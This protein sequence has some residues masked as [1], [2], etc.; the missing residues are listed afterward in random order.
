LTGRFA[1]VRLFAAMNLRTEP[2]RLCFAVAW[3]LPSCLALV[4]MA[5]CNQD[6]P[7]DG[8]SIDPSATDA[9]GRP[10]RRSPTVPT[11]SPSLLQNRE[12]ETSAQILAF[13]TGDRQSS[14]ILLEKRF[15]TQARLG[16]VYRYE[17]KVT[18]L[19]AWP[20]AG[21]VVREDFPP[22]FTVSAAE[23][24]NVATTRPAPVVTT[25]EP[26][27]RR[28]PAEPPLPQAPSTRP[29]E[30]AGPPPI[31]VMPT[32]SNADLRYAAPTGYYRDVSGVWAATATRRERR[33]VIAR[34]FI[35]GTMEPHE[36]RTIPVAGVSDE[37]GKLDTRTTVTYAPVLAG[38]TDVINPILRLSKE[39][40]RHAEL[41]DLIDI[42]YVVANVGVGTE[43]DVR[44]EETLPEGLAT[45][46]GQRTVR[47]QVGDLPQDQGREFKVRLRAARTGEYASRASAR[48][49]GTAAQSVEVVTAVHAPKLTIAATGPESEYVGKAAGY[50]ITVT[51][52]GDAAARNT[53][54][55]ASADGGAQVAWAAVDPIAA[56]Q[57]L[58]VGVIEPGQ[59]RKVRVTARPVQG[60]AMN[61]RVTAKSDCADAVTANART[62]VQ[63]IASLVM[64]VT[65]QDD[66]VRVGEAVKYRITVQN[67]GSGPD[68]NVKVVAVLPPQLQFVSAGG[69]TAGT[70]EGQRVTF[71]S[72]ADIPPG[73]SATWVVEAKAAQAGDARFRAELTSESLAEPV[74]GTQ[75][76]R[77]Y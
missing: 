37:L 47:I 28:S 43:T 50:D 22:S 25:G 55:T 76:T 44:I 12:R 6:K 5:G 68:R 11:S 61:V 27:T 33:G 19:T 46:D 15:P 10:I 48:G 75:P 66:P 21:V 54:L 1:A 40:P 57:R 49:Y 60:G 69:P 31:P 58:P 35:V 2:M 51:N 71:G 52:V 74:I 14:V 73:Q 67:T 53:Y 32:G 3:L 64:D 29:A 63:V 24:A 36:V 45:E 62:M 39:G 4:L 7:A 77:I 65:D 9:T 13:P 42:R 41:C 72:L 26:T 34:E 30:P 70:A 16:Q 23:A 59:S 8:G 18:N 17:L 20:V 56:G 38:G